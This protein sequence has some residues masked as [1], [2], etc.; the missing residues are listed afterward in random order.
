METEGSLSCSQK[1][2]T[3]PYTRVT[4]RNMLFSMDRRCQTPLN[5]KQTDRPQSVVRNCLFNISTV[6]INFFVKL[7]TFTQERGRVERNEE[8]WPKR[9]QGHVA[10]CH[11]SKVGFLTWQRREILHSLIRHQD[12]LSNWH[13]K[14]VTMV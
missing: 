1:P 5:P 9:K 4:I 7:V 3:C 10:Q 8:R 12:V 14:Y 11:Q 6:T 2:A 13:V